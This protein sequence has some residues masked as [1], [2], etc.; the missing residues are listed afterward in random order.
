MSSFLL[1]LFVLALASASKGVSLRPQE[2]F[3]YEYVDDEHDIAIKEITRHLDAVEGRN[4]ALQCVVHFRNDADAIVQWLFAGS[5]G[6]EPE[7][8]V[9]N[10]SIVNDEKRSRLNAS[11]V[12][13]YEF[14]E[15]VKI[16]R[17]KLV[18][19]D[20]DKHEDEGLYQCRVVS[21]QD[22]SAVLADEHGWVTVLPESAYIVS[23]STEENKDDETV[24]VFNVED[25]SKSAEFQMGEEPPTLGPV[26]E[27]FKVGDEA[28]LECHDADDK[29]EVYWKKQGDP[30]IK[31][32]GKRLRLARLER[33]DSGLYYCTA[34]RTAGGGNAI[35]NK[36]V[37][38][39]MAPNVKTLFDAKTSRLLCRVESVPAPSIAWYKVVKRNGTSRA[40]QLIR[41]GD[42]FSTS[43]SGF[44]DGFVEAT[45]AFNGDVVKF[46][47]F[48]CEAKN[49]LGA[50]GQSIN[51]RVSEFGSQ[52]SS[53]KNSRISFVVLLICA[54][55]QTKISKWL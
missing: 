52:N 14:V 33:W 44:K 6:Q 46:G 38:V 30:N 36:T 40:L 50:N 12:T 18:V 26:K 24:T 48:R 47:E 7:L 32:K 42:E 9:S 55:F 1:A 10:G 19:K 8:L 2:D 29:W 31:G 49:R 3:G 17:H 4:A 5:K 25:A 43:L 54:A 41:D 11:L 27:I 39:E 16:E 21:K 34:N 22:E 13:H 28:V 45:L 35:N 51:L 53:A 15:D 37:N 20:L 23:P